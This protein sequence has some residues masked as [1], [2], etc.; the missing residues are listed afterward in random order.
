MAT[1]KYFLLREKPPTN[2]HILYYQNPITSWPPGSGHILAFCDI[3]LFYMYMC[4]CFILVGNELVF[5]CWSLG[6]PRLISSS[7]CA[8]VMPL[9]LEGHTHYSSPVTA[10][11]MR[12]ALTSLCLCRIMML[13]VLKHT[14]TP[15]KFWFL[16]NFL[17]PTFKVPVRI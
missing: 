6:L 4:I 10:G 12:W 3:Y 7:V 15:V 8:C 17:S 2:L 9:G 13:S 16:K 5:K 1:D 14:K 11:T